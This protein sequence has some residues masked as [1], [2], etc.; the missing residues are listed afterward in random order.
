MTNF[1]KTLGYRTVM[2]ALHLTGAQRVLAPLTRGRGLVYM[3]HRVV[4]ARDD[5]FQPNAFLE[6]T[7]EFLETVI[8]DTRAAGIEFVSIAEA[9]RRLVAG[10]FANRFAVMTLDDGYQDNLDIALGVF[11]RHAV[12]FTVFASSGIADAT[13]ELW[14]L[15]LERIIAEN[16]QIRIDF[17]GMRETVPAGTTAQKNAAYERL[18]GWIGAGLDEHAQRRAIRALADWAGLDMAALCRSLAM[19]WDGLRRLAAEPLATI[20]A[21]TV[22]HHAVARMSEAEARDQIVRDMERHEAELG[23]RPEFFAYPYGG[24]LAAGPRDFALAAELGFKLAVTT[25][26]GQIFP[27]HRTHLTALPRV[28]LNGLYQKRRYAELLRDG[29]PLALYNGFRRLDVA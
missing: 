27:A 12:P 29:V 28:S 22:G 6:V 25:R 8:L 24:K 17:E 7:P 23:K 9:H 2:D 14:W 15:A 13:C 26:P 10:E 3:L 11:R 4:G 20:G 16:S 18:C 5:E 19:D 21:H 1:W